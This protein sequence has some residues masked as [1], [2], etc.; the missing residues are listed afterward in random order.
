MFAPL[1]AI[2]VATVAVAQPTAPSFQPLKLAANGVVLMPTTQP[3]G[4]KALCASSR[5][6]Q[7]NSQPSSAA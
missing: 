1:F 2:V 7:A 5:S 3:V 4:L 6:S